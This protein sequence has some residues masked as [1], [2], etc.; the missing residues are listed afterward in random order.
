MAA[1]LE[2]VGYRVKDLNWYLTFFEEVYG[3]GVEK[4]KVHPTGLR[5]VWLV[6]GLQLVEDPAFEGED[7]GRA[8]HVCLLVDDLEGIRAAALA[9]GC[10]ELPQHHWVELPDGQKIEM[11]AAADGAI[12]ALKNQPKR[13]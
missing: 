12:E 8:H 2:H 13:K 10:K 9:H 3:M 11:F 6:G 5:E 7:Y 4:Q 1:Y